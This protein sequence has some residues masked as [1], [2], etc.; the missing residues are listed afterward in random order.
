VAGGYR[1]TSEARANLDEICAFV[2]EDS[3]DGALRVLDAFERAFGQL[4]AMPGIG[5]AREDLTTRPVK[6]WNVYSYLVVYDPAST[7]LTIIA[8]LHG[9]RDIE[10]LLGGMR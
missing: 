3:S 1:L 9:A 6:F 2:A 4:V 5:H 7:P 8:I 10:R